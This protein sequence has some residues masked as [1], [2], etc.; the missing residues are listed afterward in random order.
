MDPLTQSLAEQASSESGWVAGAGSRRAAA[1]D[2]YVA[3]PA[4]GDS[5]R[6]TCTVLCP[7]CGCAVKMLETSSWVAG[8]VACSCF[9]RR[10]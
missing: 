7:T 8:L 10:R 4:C 5:E 2:P 6:D 1:A 9:F 3:S